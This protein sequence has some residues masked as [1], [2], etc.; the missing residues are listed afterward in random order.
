MNSEIRNCQNCKADFIIEPDDFSFYEKIKVPPP[1]FCSECRMIR[2]F[3]YRNEAMLFR[4]IDG[5]SGK[6]IFSGFSPKAEVVTYESNFWFSSDWDPLNNSFNYD[7]SKSFFNQFKYLM[8][9]APV[10]S[11]STYNL[12]NSDY[13]N[14]ISEAK[15]SY[16]CFN[17]DY[18]E[19]SAYIRKMTH[20]KESF[21]LYD[22]SENELC[23]ECVLTDKS[24]RTFFSLDCN[25][26]IDVWF[27]KGLK[28]C[29]NCF[30]CVNLIKQSYCIFNKKYTKEEYEDKINSFNLNSYNSI[31][32]IKDKISDFW[33]KFPVK[34]NHNINIT[35][36]TG[37][38]IFN[39]KNVKNSYSVRNGENLKYCQDI[40]PNASNSYDYFVWGPGENMY[41]AVGC[42]LGAFN[43]KFCFNC[44]EDI[45]NLEYCAYCIG[46]KDCFGCVG[47]SKRQYCI[48]N[49][50]YKKEKYFEL[51]EKIKKQMND[52]PYIDSQGRVYQYGEFFPVE[53][54]P[55]AYNESSAQSFYPLDE[56]RATEQGFIWRSNDLKNYNI[57]ISAENF[58]DNIFNVRNS[59]TEDIIEC[60]ECKRP[61]R[62]IEKEL[63]FY[64][65]IGISL[66]HKCHECR[67]I[68][69]FKLVNPPKLWHRT[70]MKEGCTNEFETSYAPDRPEIVYCE[71]C[72][73]QEIY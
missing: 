13:C 27:S 23:Y 6:E 64:K 58:P 11:R 44:W 63:Q 52:M 57:T 22:G 25:N 7:F 41:E 73:Q 45:Q 62:I 24:Y 65:R 21:D 18:I 2:R 16:L 1:T 39:S 29:N 69:R 67:F 48:F 37:E 19:N 40:Q 50:Q 43:I 54:S 30:G 31:N 17:C 10:P 59:I 35:D 38:R 9:I 34:Y 47:L 46:C 55:I 14:E 61:Y 28:G 33:L 3:N 68:E 36:S 42:G 53:I 66:P 71:K 72:Y 20:V 8:S 51:V 26:C 60:F 4:R 32:L 70:C 5:R 49:R 15:N 56:I 12:L